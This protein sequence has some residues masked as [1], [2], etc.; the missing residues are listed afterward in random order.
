M[1]EINL[2]YKNHNTL[3][4]YTISDASLIMSF[5][6][7]AHAVY[8]DY[9]MSFKTQ[10]V[11]EWSERDSWNEGRFRWGWKKK[12]EHKVLPLCDTASGANRRQIDS[13]FNFTHRENQ[14]ES[15]SVSVLANDS[16]ATIAAAYA[17]CFYR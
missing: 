5:F 8:N 11:A 9:I 4:S 10:L 13:V 17:R 1:Q 7:P 16:S 14:F 12:K 2:K 3:N 6:F 15:N